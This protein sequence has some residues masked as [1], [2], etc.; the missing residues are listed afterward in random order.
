[1]G[2][3]VLD[4]AKIMGDDKIVTTLKFKMRH[5]R[6]QSMAQLKTLLPEAI[7]QEFRETALKDLA[8]VQNKLRTLGVLKVQEENEIKNL[9]KQ[10]EACREKVK[11]IEK[12]Q[13][14][15]NEKEKHLKEMVEKLGAAVRRSTV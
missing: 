1:M 15:M 12:A 2:R 6:T 7:N 4:F 10:V 13:K 14:E 8:K 5:K 9:E 11:R 3:T